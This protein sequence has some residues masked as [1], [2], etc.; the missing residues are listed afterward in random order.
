MTL[1]G[2]AALFRTVPLPAIA[3][4]FMDDRVFAWMRLA[5]PNPVM[6]RRITRPGA[7]FPVTEAI[8]KSVLAHDS[9][10]AA[11]AEGRLYLADYA[12][13]EGVET[14]TIRGLRKYLSAPLA[15]FAVKPHG[16]R[17]TPIAIQCGQT[18][19]HNPVFTPHDGLA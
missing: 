7:R 16:G 15:L 3:A 8:Y 19:G 10:A 1:E 4:D 6:L 5:G 13:L 2:Y 9:L 11:G 12:E 17:L 14:G 18:P